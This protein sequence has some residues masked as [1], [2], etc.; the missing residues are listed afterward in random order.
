MRGPVHRH[1]VCRGRRVRFD[2]LEPGDIVS[3]FEQDGGFAFN[4]LVGERAGEEGWRP[5]RGNDVPLPSPPNVAAR[6]GEGSD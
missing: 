6:V 5:I 3:V 4:L 1:L 2:D